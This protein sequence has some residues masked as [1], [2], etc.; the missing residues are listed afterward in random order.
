MSTLKKGDMRIKY[1]LNVLQVPDH[2]IKVFIVVSLGCGKK[3]IF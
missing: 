1:N 2:L 3:N